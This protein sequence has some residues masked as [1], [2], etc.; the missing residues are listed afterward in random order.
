VRLS[1]IAWQVYFYASEKG[2]KAIQ[3]RLLGN[4]SDG[5]FT[6]TYGYRGNGLVSYTHGP[7]STGLYTET[8]GQYSSGVR[9]VTHGLHSPAIDATNANTISDISPVGIK[10]EATGNDG[11]GLIAKGERGIWAESTRDM[12]PAL[13]AWRSPAGGLAA[14]FQGNVRISK[15][16]GSG[17]YGTAVMELGEGLDYAEGFNVSQAAEVMPGMVLVID[18][19]NPGTLRASTE[20]YDHKVAGIVSGARDLGSAVKV[21]GEQFDENVALAGRVYCNVD[22]GYGA[23]EAG[24]LLTTSATPGYAMVVKDYNQAQGAILGKAM[25]RLGEGQ[26]GQILVLVTLQ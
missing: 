16:A 24:D 8:Y 14:D 20:P 6:D 18:R 22:A 4:N 3:V 21:G 17:R 23:V 25:E 10:A 13:I 19:D 11:I 5:V 7:N 12:G 1:R 15:Y 2:S 26:K 9:I